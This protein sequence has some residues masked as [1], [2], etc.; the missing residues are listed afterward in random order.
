VENDLSEV[1]D[2]RVTY[3][4]DAFEGLRVMDATMARARGELPEV[5]PEEEAKK[6]ERKARHERSQRVAA[7]RKA[8]EAETAGPIPERSDVTVDNPIPTPPFWG[9]RVVK[10]IALADY[11]G[12][13]DERALFLGQWGLR[14]AKQ[15][16]GPTYEELVETEG[17]PRLR[18]WLERMSTEGVLAGASLVYGYFPVVSEKDALVVLTEPRPDAPERFRFE[19]PRQ[20]RDRH[21][22]LADF[23]RPRALAVERGEVDVLPLHL[24]TMGQPIADYAN[25]LFA[26]D[27]YRDY[28]EVH[29][30]GVQLTEALAEYWHRR[31]REELTFP[32]GDAVAAEDPEN[33]EEFFK[34]GF[35]G[36]RYSLGYGACPNL[37]DRTKIVE[38]LEPGRIGVELSEELQLHP[39]Q[40]TDAMVAHHPEAKYFNAG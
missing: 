29:G 6:A 32:S 26:K 2:G 3:A 25:E 12:M 35:R 23:W 31:V 16:S 22:C 30:L 37:D 13:V 39:E 4:R 28:L 24:V 1:Y 11:S 10:G 21:L 18:Y 27:A 34:L 19:F 9:T 5:D 20:R 33:I 17:R 8:A 14:G 40:S 15:G 36:A 7:K 38:L